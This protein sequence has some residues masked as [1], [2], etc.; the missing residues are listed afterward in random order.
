MTDKIRNVLDEVYQERQRQLQKWG[1]QDHPQ[2]T[3]PE[4]ML[5]G[6]TIQEMT[7]FVKSFN[8]EHDNPFWGT[9][10]L[11]E[12]LEALSEREGSPELRQELLQVAAVAVAAVENLDA[13]NNEEAA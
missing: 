6:F 12:V 1:V 7:S 8:D 2:G 11:E 13:R 4:V 10:L 3:G 5:F 9:I